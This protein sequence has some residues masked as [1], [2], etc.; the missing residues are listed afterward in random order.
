MKVL[1][2][3]GQ[4]SLDENDTKRDSNLSENYFSLYV[5]LIIFEKLLIARDYK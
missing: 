5:V 2:M 3:N 4:D 1:S